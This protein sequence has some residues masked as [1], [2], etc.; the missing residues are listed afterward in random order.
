VSNVLYTRLR[1][2]SSNRFRVNV[3]ND[4]CCD[5]GWVKNI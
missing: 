3:F 2:I 1:Y 4:P 5:C